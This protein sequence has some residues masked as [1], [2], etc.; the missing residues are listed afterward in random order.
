MRRDDISV[1]GLIPARGGSKGI[2]RKNVIDLAGLPLIG[3]T[4]HA[5]RRSRILDKVIVS[6]DDKEIASYARKH[7][8]EVPFIRPAELSGDTATSL[9]VVLFAVEWLQNEWDY[10]PDFVALLQPTSPFR[11]S[12]T[13]D[14]GVMQLVDSRAESLVAVTRSVKHPHWMYNL[15]EGVLGRYGTS[16]DDNLTRRQEL[17]PVYAI[18]GALYVTR[19]EYLL[20]ERRIV[21][22]Q[23][24]GL[25]MKQCESIDIDDP[26]DLDVAR[27]IVSSGLVPGLKGAH[28]L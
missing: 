4:I 2:P 25:V 17:P 11:T 9:D 13:I 27:A 28:Q 10:R 26:W 8:V 24:L 3:W 22:D 15:H 19:T 18:N 14:E 7:G 20:R 23:P 6:T 16:G 1:L 12:E 5:A 21:S